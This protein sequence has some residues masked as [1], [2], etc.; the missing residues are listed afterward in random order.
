MKFVTIVGT[1][2]QFI[3]LGPVSQALRDRHQEVLVHT[4]QHY[5]ASMSGDFFRDLTLPEPDYNLEIGSAA[6]G[7][8]TGRMLAAIEEVLLKERPDGVVVFGDTNSTLAGALAAAKLSLPV[9]HVE[10]GVRSYNRSMPEEINRVLTDHS[11]TWLFCPTENARRQASREGLTRGVEVVGDV[12]Y[13][14]VRRMRPQLAA[15]AQTLLPSLNLA[16]HAYVV[17]TLHRPANTDDPA[18]LRR[19]AAALNSLATPIVF[20][21]HPR[22]RQAIQRYGVEW[23]RWVH[24][25]EP[26]GHLDMLTLVQS[27]RHVATDSGGLQKEAFLLGVSCITLREETE[28]PETLVDGWNVLVG[29]RSEDIVAAFDRCE[30]RMR[31]P[32]P[33]GDG[34][35]ARKIA[36][37]LQ[38]LP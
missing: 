18:A 3:K 16:P 23:S 20:P 36:Q 12:M 24:L 9:A 22:T 31:G 7:A 19:I 26:L 27:A 14:V 35:A 5:D 10:A 11:A 28:W 38:T 17:A 6:H 2:P 13:D 33:F 32:H 4:G 29:N 8:Q 30:P 15:H 1:R 34:N 37:A 21:V 25:V